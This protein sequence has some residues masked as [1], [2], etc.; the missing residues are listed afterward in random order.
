MV[1]ESLQDIESFTRELYG[2]NLEIYNSD[3][4]DFVKLTNGSAAHEIRV[5]IGDNKLHINGQR[6]SGEKVNDIRCDNNKKSLE[7]T[8]SRVL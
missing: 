7:D 3:K 6:Y 8:L 5:S 2:N 1:L 4:T